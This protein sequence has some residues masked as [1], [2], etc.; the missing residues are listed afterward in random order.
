VRQKA[1]VIGTL[2]ILLLAGSAGYSQA[3]GRA[4]CSVR[5][6][7]RNFGELKKAGTMSPIERFVFSLVL[8][9]SK[10]PAQCANHG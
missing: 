8:S 3:Y 9:N 5:T 1:A 10:T 6:F 2:A 7:Q 4:A